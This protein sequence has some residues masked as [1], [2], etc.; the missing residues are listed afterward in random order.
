MAN[1]PELAQVTDTWERPDDWPEW[2]CPKCAVGISRI[3]AEY[4]YATS[5]YNKEPPPCPVGGIVVSEVQYHAYPCGHG[6]SLPR[7]AEFLAGL[8]ASW[9]APS[10]RGADPDPAYEARRR[11]FQNLID[12]RNNS[13]LRTNKVPA[14]QWLIIITDQ[15]R[16]LRPGLA[17]PPV[18]QL[19]GAA[20]DWAMSRGLELPPVSQP[21]T[22]YSWSTPITS[23]Y[24]DI[25]WDVA[26]PESPEDVHNDAVRYNLAAMGMLSP[27]SL[28]KTTGLSTNELRDMIGPDQ[29]RP[30]PQP[31][32]PPPEEKPGLP[33]YMKAKRRVRR[34]KEES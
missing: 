33:A 20:I 16:R 17:T 5:L 1:D 4:P 12:Y 31:D 10:A 2:P 30:A 7:A 15:L 29:L 14:E 9:R 13:I 34:G 3:V 25:G 27:S 19:S 22:N 11:E 24:A 26:E 18:A 6:L 23:R 8:A 32:P 21:P 28:L